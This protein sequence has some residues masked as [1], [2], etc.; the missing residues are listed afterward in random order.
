MGYLILLFT[1]VP[2]AELALLIKIGR[3]CGLGN[4]LLI[5]IATGILGAFLLKIQGIGI[6]RRINNELSRGVIPSDAIF[7]GL[8]IFCGGLFL[9]TPGVIT[10]V[11]GILLLFPFSRRLFKQWAKSRM[12]D[13]IARGK[14]IDITNFKRYE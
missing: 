10:D 11:L 4:T 3:V 1:I 12:E 2:I 7:D 9:V 14:I 13:S 5:V 6:L 8:F